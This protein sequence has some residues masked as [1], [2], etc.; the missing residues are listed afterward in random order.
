MDNLFAFLKKKLGP[1]AEIEKNKIIIDRDI[2]GKSLGVAW[3][4]TAD[5]PTIIKLLYLHGKTYA[6]C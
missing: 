3:V 1:T 5:R 6:S 2:R 4:F